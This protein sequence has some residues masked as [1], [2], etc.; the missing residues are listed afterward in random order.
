MLTLTTHAYSHDY[1]FFLSTTTTTT[2]IILFITVNGE[3]SEF[4]SQEKVRNAIRARTGVLGMEE[5]QVSKEFIA[6][7]A[8]RAAMRGGSGSSMGGLDLS[9]VSD[10][11]S[12]I[13]SINYDPEDEMTEEE[14]LASDPLGY[15]PFTEQL[16][17]ELG[18]TT[19]PD[20]G[21]TFSRV[22]LL[23][24]LAFSTGFLIIETDA[25]VRELYMS[26]GFI[27]RPEDIMNAK[28]AGLKLSQEL[29]AK[30]VE[31]AS[32]GLSLPDIG[33]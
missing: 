28:D 23:V 14:K 1:H 19:F 10:G 6:E 20:I 32:D 18:E 25:L 12:Q 33:L 16:N 22:V 9:K 8:A 2:T 17:F 24:A 7:A 5:S 27:P 11:S 13:L 4:E 15:K 29:A 3:Q 30:V 21:A 31:K 26:K